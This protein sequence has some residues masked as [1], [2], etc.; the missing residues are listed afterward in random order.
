LDR[1]EAKGYKVVGVQ[2]IAGRI[3]DNWDKTI[4]AVSQWTLYKPI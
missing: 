1:L 2:T 4:D 3:N